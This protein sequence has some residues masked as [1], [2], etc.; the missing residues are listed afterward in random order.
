MKKLLSLMLVIVLILGFQG[1]SGR[2]NEVPEEKNLDIDRSV[3]HVNVFYPRW[4]TTYPTEEKID[5]WQNYINDK[6]S[7]N[8]NLTCIDNKVFDSIGMDS[9]GE[10]GIGVDLTYIEAATKL[11]GLIYT[12]KE[13][14]LKL[15]AA[16]FLIP[17]NDYADD[18]IADFGIKS[19]IVNQFK[20]SGGNLLGIPMTKSEYYNFRYYRAD[21]LSQWGDAPGNLDEFHEYGK[22]ISSEH[23]LYLADFSIGTFLMNFKDIFNAYG[24]FPDRLSPIGYNPEKNEIENI[25]LNYNFESALIYI[26]SLYDEG[27]LKNC[28]SSIPSESNWNSVSSYTPVDTEN[29]TDF[30]IGIP[31]ESVAGETYREMNTG[32][33]C[34]AV[35]RNTRNAEEQLTA[36]KRILLNNYSGLLDLA[37]GIEGEDYSFNENY[38]STRYYDESGKSI[39]FINIMTNLNSDISLPVVPEENLEMLDLIL[40]FNENS[41]KYIEELER[42]SEGLIKYYKPLWAYISDK[43]RLYPSQM[44]DDMYNMFYKIFNENIPVSEALDEFRSKYDTSEYKVLLDEV[45]YNR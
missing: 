44:E 6:Y 39:N 30:R 38:V 40:K 27:L 17:L 31:F 12:N 41:N 35:L 8:M 33:Y 29:F 18:F 9:S 1:C 2:N 20:D 23:S 32:G 11:D 15:N 24:C 25:L 36:I 22:Y 10:Y 3:L 45:N 19:D 21:L 5:K 42:N 26:K 13:E 7:V 16:G 34:I 37:Y 4:P 14:L 43:S 28:E